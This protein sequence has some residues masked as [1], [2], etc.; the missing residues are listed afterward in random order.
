MLLSELAP[1]QGWYVALFSSLAHHNKTTC[2]L[3]NIFLKYQFAIAYKSFHCTFLVYILG[4]WTKHVYVS[5]Q[6]LGNL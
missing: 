5:C 6:M 4:V 3:C 1:H 2:I